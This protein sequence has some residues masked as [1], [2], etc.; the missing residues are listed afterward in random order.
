MSWSLRASSE[1]IGTAIRGC[2]SSRVAKS[3]R[4]IVRQL[5]SVVAV[6]GAALHM[7]GQQAEFPDEL[8]GSEFNRPLAKLDAHR[9]VQD[10]EHPE[11][12]WPR[13]I[14]TDPFGASSRPAIAAT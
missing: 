3:A 8:V 4:P 10:H 14:S 1:S 13:S 9:P 5:T 12:G 6:L 11:P 2:C 7:V